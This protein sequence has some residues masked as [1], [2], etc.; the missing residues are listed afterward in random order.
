MSDLRE[1]LNQSLSGRYEIV[2]ELGQGG[3]ATVY[4]AQDLRHD[5]AIALKVVHPVLAMALGSDRFEREIATTARLQHP[6]ILPLIDSGMVGNLPFYVMPLVTG[7]SLRQRLDREGSLPVEDTLAIATE[8]AGALEYAHRQGLVHRDIKPENILLEDGHA[9]IA[10]FG[11][12]RDLDAADRQ[13]LTETGL[14]IGT[15]NY[16]SPEQGAG[17]RRIDGRSDQYSLACT[18]YEMLAGEPPFTG[19]TFQSVVARHAR[20][21]VPPVTTVR[22]TVPPGMAAALERG[23]AK[24][25]ADRFSSVAAFAVALADPLL[26]RTSQRSGVARPRRRL[27]W[28]AVGLATLVAGAVLIARYVGA[29]AARPLDPRRVAILPFTARCSPDYAVWCE[30]V[31]DLL[32][33]TFSGAGEYSAAD[34]RAVRRMVSEQGAGGEPE[35]RVAAALGA[36]AFIVGDVTESGGQLRIT[37]SLY[38]TGEAGQARAS[39]TVEGTATTMFRMVDE[40]AALVVAGAESGET[41]RLTRLA[42]ATTDSLAAL[43]LF[44]QS[45]SRI[46]AGQFDS[47]LVLLVRAVAI[48]TGFTLG[49]ARLAEV[50]GYSDRHDLLPAVRH[51]AGNLGR[52]S[53]RDSLLVAASV[54]PGFERTLAIYRQLLRRDS[55]DPGVWGLLGEFLIHN[56]GATAY[57]FDSAEHAFQRAIALG[58]SS[59]RN[60][61]HLNWAAGVAGDSATYDAALELAIRRFPD[62][63]M[64]PI[65]RVELA[66][67][68][69]D[70]AGEVSALDALRAHDRL[71]IWG[72]AVRL[73]TTGRARP[74]AAAARLL[75]TD[76][77][78]V[79]LRSLG[80]QLIATFAAAQGKWREARRALELAAALE[81]V[82]GTEIAAYLAAV[83]QLTVGREQ[84]DS[85]LRVLERQR[86][87]ASHAEESWVFP[88]QGA[89]DAITLYLQGLL[90][91]Q[92]GDAASASRRADQLVGRPRPDGL[93]V[94][95]AASLRAR[96]AVDLGRPA[97]ALHE[98]ESARSIDDY[99]KGNGSPFYSLVADRALR[100]DLLDRLA[101]PA[102]SLRWYRQL[103]GTSLFDVAWLPHSLLRSADIHTRLGDPAAA[104]AELDRFLELWRDADPELQ[105]L[106]AE[107]R[108]RRLALAR[109]R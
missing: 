84:L 3:S 66:V 47:A 7:G 93:T 50:A 1:R 31:A 100:A 79:N 46:R 18:V 51:A 12:A 13:R 5:R 33:A 65:H 92:L 77:Q 10:D 36:G 2:A 106:V 63:F 54:A 4:R 28:L 102:E 108:A 83:P 62:G 17:E 43:K 96:A 48:D 98:L 20:D 75:T 38:R 19:A 25:P 23:L 85:L 61:N 72:T 86:I 6:H 76:E 104:A 107:A 49:W 60:I 24:V 37:A 44:L 64:T 67:L 99:M 68:R 26:P 90:A 57:P 29:I 91:A 42:V 109:A 74:A 32:G 34:S 73:A 70:S 39:G 16:M 56:S 21:P 58:D 22:P 71:T 45:E 55:T 97:D 82:G 59:W 81:P 103:G 52:L 88:N 95:L 40:L 78:P 41:G 80:H 11:I 53:T 8:V 14:S 101:R 105:P 27:A 30:G 94:A 9:L 69:H 35:S 15:P 87:P 89:H